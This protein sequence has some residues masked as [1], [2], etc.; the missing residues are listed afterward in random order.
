M[1]SERPKFTNLED[2]ILDDS[3]KKFPKKKRSVLV[4]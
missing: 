1:N 3:K 4:K 2:E